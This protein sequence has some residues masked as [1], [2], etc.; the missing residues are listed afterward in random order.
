MITLISI[1]DFFW[2]LWLLPFILGS[3]L[4]WLYWKDK[5]SKM[6]ADYDDKIKGLNGRISSLEG[7]LDDCGSKRADLEIDL[8]ITK[9]RMREIEANMKVLQE[10]ASSS[11]KGN[12][13]NK[14]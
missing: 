9:G 10:S 2:W 5:Y 14:G 8:A 13:D 3:L 11:K 4:T 1:C 6:V 12:K 7:D